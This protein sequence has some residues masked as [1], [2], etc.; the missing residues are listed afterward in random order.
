[1]G[2]V[3]QPELILSTTTAATAATATTATIAIIATATATT[4]TTIIC[5]HSAI[6]TTSKPHCR[7]RTMRTATPG[8]ESAL[9]THHTHHHHSH[10]SHLSHLSHQPVLITTTTGSAL[11]TS[12]PE[13]RLKHRLHKIIRI[14]SN[15]AQTHSRMTPIKLSIS[16]L[17]RR[18]PLTGLKL[19]PSLSSTPDALV[20]IMKSNSS[21]V[22]VAES[23]AQ[24]TSTA[25]VPIMTATTAIGIIDRGEVDEG[26][27]GT[28]AEIKEENSMLSLNLGST[29]ATLATTSIVAA[30]DPTFLRGKNETQ[31]HHHGSRN[32]SS[33]SGTKHDIDV[34]DSSDD[35][36]NKG[37]DTQMAPPR[38][39]FTVS[40]SL[41]ARVKARVLQQS[42]PKQSRNQ[43]STT[44]K[45]SSPEESRGS[46]QEENLTTVSVKGSKIDSAE[47]ES[48]ASH[49]NP[50]T[51]SSGTNHF[52]DCVQHDQDRDSDSTATDLEDIT[53]M[54]IA[55]ASSARFRQ[56]KYS[57][58]PHYNA[59]VMNPN[60]NSH[61]DDDYN[62]GS[63]EQKQYHR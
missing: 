37:Y 48:N 14:P 39:G 20:P 7:T 62:S 49:S 47:V 33:S 3:D 1:M 46:N 45:Q 43:R 11:D 16:R 28:M 9:H 54:A 42:S 61:G 13:Q 63:D 52:N 21:S 51:L 4:T 18:K 24:P 58:G 41:F 26:I 15:V 19:N 12:V 31:H 2:I 59:V 25:T 50:N 56:R 35:K 32:S 57:F 8:F 38:E 22:F 10:L 17:D 23:V 5:I 6:S 29:L 60:N 36:K 34:E 44:Q 30:D 53:A 40:T 27:G 55:A